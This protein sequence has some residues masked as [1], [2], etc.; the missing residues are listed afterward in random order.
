MQ[1]YILKVGMYV[2]ADMGDALIKKYIFCGI[3]KTTR[4]VKDTKGTPKQWGP[5]RRYDLD[6]SV[7]HTAKTLWICKKQT[8]FCL[9][10]LFRCAGIVALSKEE[11]FLMLL[12]K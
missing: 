9:F 11:T 1:P 2:S 12:S 3:V 7:F 4:K 5:F 10:H 6:I 8:D